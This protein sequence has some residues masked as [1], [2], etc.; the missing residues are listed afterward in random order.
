MHTDNPLWRGRTVLIIAALLVLTAAGCVSRRATPNAAA[1]AAGRK[2]AQQIFGP[3]LELGVA[4]GLFQ[5]EL[6]RWPTNYAELCSFS[7]AVALSGIT[8]YD[9]IDFAPQPDGG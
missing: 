4:I 8:N 6:D 1:D 3:P 7:E 9:R 5:G 2:L